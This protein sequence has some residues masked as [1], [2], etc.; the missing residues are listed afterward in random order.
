[1]FFLI[2]GFPFP[3][4]LQVE[5]FRKNMVPIAR[6]RDRRDAL[7]VRCPTRVNQQVCSHCSSSELFILK[8]CETKL[9]LLNSQG[10]TTKRGTLCLINIES[11][12]HPKFVYTLYQL[13]RIEADKNWEFKLVRKY[14]PE[15][16]V[17]NHNFVKTL[18]C[19]NIKI[20]NEQLEF[21]MKLGGIWDAVL[22]DVV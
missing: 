4:Q 8:W 12:P 9:S 21:E 20:W 15:F 6:P 16:D 5:P 1:M 3:R 17:K 14:N 19:I 2:K 10:F 11:C 22:Q 13:N 7:W 18:F